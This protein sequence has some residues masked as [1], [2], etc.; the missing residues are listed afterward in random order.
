M[1]K[2]KTISVAGHTNEE[3]IN[4]IILNIPNYG[5]TGKEIREVEIEVILR[6]VRK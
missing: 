4:D 3:V 5:Q 1:K 2:S 6:D